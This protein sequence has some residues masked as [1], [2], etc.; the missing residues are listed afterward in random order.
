[1]SDHICH[2]T[3]A[4][5][6]E[7]SREERERRSIASV[8]PEERALAEAALVSVEVRWDVGHSVKAF[9]PTERGFDSY[10]GLL[11]TG[12]DGKFL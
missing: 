10:F 6:S 2:E 3:R 4:A 9:W 7:V 11:T 8:S 5:P 12:Y 1:M